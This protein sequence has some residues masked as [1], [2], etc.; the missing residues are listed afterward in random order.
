VPPGV[1]PV[2]PHRAQG[3]G[4]CPSLAVHEVVKDQRPVRGAEQFGKPYGV[5]AGDIDQL[6]V[7]DDCVGALNRECHQRTAGLVSD[8][9]GPALYR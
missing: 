5:A 8:G 4:L 9:P 1:V 7:V 2:D 6:V 3:A